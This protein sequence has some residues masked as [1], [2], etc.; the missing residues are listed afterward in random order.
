MEIY[1]AYESQR[2]K[3]RYLNRRQ[4]QFFSYSLDE[5][6]AQE[7]AADDNTAET[8]ERQQEIRKLRQAIRSLTEREQGIIIDYFFYDYSLRSL[9]RKYGV[10]HSKINSEI[11]TALDKLRQYIINNDD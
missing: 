10:S 7:I 3:E 6:C 8:V 5:E 9:G 1:K 4:N 2:N 11:Q